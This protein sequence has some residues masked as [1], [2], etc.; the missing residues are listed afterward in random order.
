MKNFVIFPLLHP[1]AAL[2]QGNLLGPLKEDFKK[3]KE[4]LD[5]NT[6]PA[7]PTTAASPAA[8][9][10]HIEPPQPAQMDLFGA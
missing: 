9:T 6:K 3:L 2:H 10:L 1:A 7:E 5:R 8:A 4:F